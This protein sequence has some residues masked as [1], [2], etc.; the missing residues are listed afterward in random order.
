M[1]S[2]V[3]AR[4]YRCLKML[5]QPLGPFHVL[6]GPNASGKTTFLDAVAFLSDL[7]SDGL[8]AA[9]AKRSANFMDLLWGRTGDRFELAVEAPIP[10]ER[11]I[12]LESPQHDTIR[13]E[14][15]VGL[16][17]ANNQLQVLDEQVTLLSSASHPPAAPEAVSLFLGDVE[18]PAQAVAG[19]LRRTGRTRFAGPPWPTILTPEV[20]IDDRYVIASPKKPQSVLGSLEEHRFPASHWL[21]NTLRE[22]VFRFELSN[23]ALRQPSPPGKGIR[24]REDGSNLPWVIGALQEKHP[25]RFQDWLAHLRTGLPDL[26]GIRVVERPED[27]HRY[28]M[29]KYHN[30]L[31]VPSWM[32]S[33]GTLRLLALTVIPYLPDFRGTCLIEEPENSIHPLNIQTVMQSLKS[34]YEG[35]VLVATQ[36]PVVLAEARLEETL[37]FTRSSED[38]TSVTAGDQ[39][40]NLREWKGEVSLGTLFAG[41]VLG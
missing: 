39:H 20:D 11:Q 6:V 32:L 17:K 13:Y 5:R 18:T 38:G 37:V 1:I 16:D 29:L 9:V 28:L 25:E 36:S 40:P 27:K 4:N 23:F 3:E 22:G 7:V 31:E 19:K 15:A 24:L 12:P 41:G 34:V 2:L 10:E 26:S 8:E 30:G 35:Q 21:A 14:V 33:D